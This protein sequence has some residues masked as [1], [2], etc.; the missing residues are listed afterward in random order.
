MVVPL[1]LELKSIS[2]SLIQS[3]CLGFELLLVQNPKP[4]S[5]WTKKSNMLV[6]NTPQKWVRKTKL[7]FR[8]KPYTIKTNSN[9]ECLPKGQKLI[10]HFVASNLE[11]FNIHRSYEHTCQTW[12]WTCW[13]WNVPNISEHTM[14][15]HMYNWTIRISLY[16][17]V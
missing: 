15:V 10:S 2:Q 6:S 5:V 3:L 13:K 9:N 16:R 7:G 12:T 1:F 11:V 17:F 14:Q 4:S 8:M